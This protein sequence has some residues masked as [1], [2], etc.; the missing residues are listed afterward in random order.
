MVFVNREDIAA[1]AR[2]RELKRA[3][4]VDVGTIMR[5]VATAGVDYQLR[6]RIMSQDAYQASSGLQ[7]RYNQV[8]FEMLD[9]ERGTVVWS[10]LYEFANVAADDVVYR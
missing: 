3:G 8:S 5:T 9:M 7:H 2:E 6:G 10:G 4:V 1:V